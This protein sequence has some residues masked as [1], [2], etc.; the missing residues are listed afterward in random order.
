[1]TEENIQ[2][3]R[4]NDQI[5][6]DGMSL[7]SKHK[8]FVLYFKGLDRI[9]VPYGVNELIKKAKELKIPIPSRKEIKSWQ[10]KHIQ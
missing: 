8:V 10:R 9:G 6:E 3:Y 7:E 2:N 5:S 1:M 4:A